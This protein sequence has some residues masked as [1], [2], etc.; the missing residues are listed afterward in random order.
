MR[1]GAQPGHINVRR[2]PGCAHMGPLPVRTQHQMSEVPGGHM[3][4]HKARDLGSAPQ[5]QS[6]GPSFTFYTL[7]LVLIHKP[8]LKLHR[9]ARGTEESPVKT[10]YKPGTSPAW[11]CHVPGGPRGEAWMCR[12]QCGPSWACFEQT[13]VAGVCTGSAQL[14]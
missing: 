4:S 12:Y 9:L 2:V 8:G 6:R 1:A 14:R 11:R 10:L 5:A 7:H 13:G 3:V